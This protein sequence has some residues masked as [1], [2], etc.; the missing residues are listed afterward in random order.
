MST[1]VAPIRHAARQLV[2][3]LHLLDGRVECCGLPLAECHLVTELAS[4]GEATATELCDRLVLEKSTISRVVKKLVDKGLICAACCADDRRARILCLTSEGKAKAAELERHAVR[5][6]SSALEYL[7][8]DEPE[9]VIDGLSRYAK[10]LRHARL[11]GDMEIRPI[12]RDDNPRVAELMRQ[13]MTEFGMAGESF[14]ISD[15]E[16]DDMY[17]AY[18]DGGSAFLVIERNGEILGC[19][20]FGPLRGADKGTCELRKMYFLPAIRGNGMGSR[21]LR[22]ILQLARKAGYSRCYL[23]TMHNMARARALYRKHGFEETG[24][25]LGRTGHSGCNRFMTLEL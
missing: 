17:G 9:R 11:S 16:V 10:A 3:E 24:A 5:Q 2:R 15:P 12:R 20:G 14:S 18:R 8:H 1:A 22:R 25:P 21:L 13:V 6:V 19:G 23:E 7:G 4:M